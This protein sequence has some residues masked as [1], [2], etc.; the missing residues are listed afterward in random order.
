MQNY[1]PP[2][3]GF[4]IQ[5]QQPPYQATGYPYPPPNQPGGYMPQNLQPQGMP[6]MAP[7]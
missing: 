4:N 7:G 5:P 6:M 2:Q 1:G 3:P